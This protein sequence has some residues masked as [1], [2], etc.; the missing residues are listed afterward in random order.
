MLLEIPPIHPAVSASGWWWAV[1]VGALLLAVL[2][3]VV[4]VWRWHALRPR[5]QPVDDSLDVLRQ[6]ALRRID[7]AAASPEPHDAAQA[8]SRA[9][10]R[11][12]GTASD[13]DADY[14]TA[15]EL[16]R[17]AETDPRL[18]P[19]AQFTA[20]LQQAAFAPRTQP[21]VAAM[22]DRAR[23]VVRAWR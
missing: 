2:L 6:D 11:F 17:D 23:E 22:A 7:E 9:V 12:V 19:A 16:A 20:D 21:D 15:E 5:P 3:L 18:V 14:S 8:L 4:G 1:A 13:G 10:R